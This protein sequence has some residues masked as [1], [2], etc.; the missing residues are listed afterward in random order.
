VI[1]VSGFGDAVRTI[2]FIYSCQAILKTP[3]LKIGYWT[4]LKSPL[5][6]DE[7][8]LAIE[9]HK[10]KTFKKRFRFPEAWLNHRSPARIEKAIVLVAIGFYDAVWHN[11]FG[12]IAQASKPFLKENPPL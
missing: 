7:M 2:T 1:N 4:K 3:Y 6:V 12:E 10:S 8:P 11:T 5:L 9:E